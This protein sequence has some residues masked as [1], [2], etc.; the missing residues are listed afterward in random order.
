MASVCSQPSVDAPTAA[1]APGRAAAGAAQRAAGEPGG[2][3]RR[4]RGRGRARRRRLPRRPARARAAQR[5]RRPAEGRLRGPAPSGSAAEPQPTCSLMRWSAR[6]IGKSRGGGT[7]CTT[8][9]RPCSASG[10]AQQ[11]TCVAPRHSTPRRPLTRLTART[12]CATGSGRRRQQRAPPA[13][14]PPTITLCTISPPCWA[15]RGHCRKRA[16][17]LL[18]AQHARDALTGASTRGHAGAH[19]ERIERLSAEPRRG[20]ALGRR[21]PQRRRAAAREQRLAHAQPPAATPAAPQHA[22]PA[23]LSLPSSQTRGVQ[24]RNGQAATPAATATSRA[25]TALSRDGTQA[26]THM[27][28]LDTNPQIPP[29]HTHKYTGHTHT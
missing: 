4:R 11:G 17:H 29:T 6:R 14:Q 25:H 10:A 22:S 8:R 7:E 21:P 19:P 26:Q 24:A 20:R 18:C 5:R 9:A 16:R 3:R 1:R 28:T 12:P 15:L 13:L 23:A 2:R 27:Y